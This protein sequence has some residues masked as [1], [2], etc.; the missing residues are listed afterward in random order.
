M[1]TPNVVTIVGG[2]GNQLFQ[3]AFGQH[4]EQLTGRPTR[5]D[6]RQFQS[7]RLHGGRLQVTVPF[8][9]QVAEARPSDLS[10]SG[11]L[12]GDPNLLRIFFH[13]SRSAG[14]FV[15]IR[16]D[17]N[18]A[19]GRIGPGSPPAFFH[20]YWQRPDFARATAA[21]LRFRP[22]IEAAASAT[23]AQLGL[24]PAVD[25]VV[26]VR[27]GDFLK[28][29]NAPHL[30][31]PENRY[32]APLMRQLSDIHPRRFL[33]LS[34]DVASL[35][36]GPLSRFDPVFVGPDM[37][38]SA[39]IDLC[40]MSKFGT[41]LLSASSFSWWGAALNRHARPVVLAP[42]PWVKLSF[43]ADEPASA[44]PFE[45]WHLVDTR[46][47]QVAGAPAVLPPSAMKW[48]GAGS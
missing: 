40:L 43:E 11:R 18:Y 32:Y 9:V 37:S 14:R 36:D 47:V 20:G 22:E 30:P 3:F 34:D 17:Y 8:D 5:Y 45:D 48:S 25:A 39:A 24:D 41:M 4:L 12:A 16:T 2:L 21:A 29:P 23:M 6:L 27:R 33:V 31:L 15:P 26:H 1:S 28:L 10:L 7:Y 46:S 42:W 44:Y 13:A 19:A 38:S 35:R